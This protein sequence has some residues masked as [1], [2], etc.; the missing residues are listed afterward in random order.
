M[1]MTGRGDLR[2]RRSES[3]ADAG[4][5]SDGGREHSQ[6]LVTSGCLAPLRQNIDPSSLIITRAPRR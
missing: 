1:M 2:F 6:F 4:L 5:L 3:G